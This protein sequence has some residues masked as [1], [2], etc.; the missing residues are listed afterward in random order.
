MGLTYNIQF[1]ADTKSLKVQ[2]ASIKEDLD[3]AFEA[4]TNSELFGQINKAVVSA[5]ALEKAMQK[6]STVNGTSFV[7]LN[8]ELKKAG[9]SASDIVSSFTS[10][11]MQKS[12]SKFIETFTTADRSALV[13]SK[14]IKE[15]GRV[16]TQSFKFSAA[17]GFLR[18]AQSSLQSGLRW[19]IDMN[20]AL[21]N[22]SIVTQKTGDDL[23]RIFE[24]IVSGAKNLNIA[25]KEYAEASLIF[26]Q[27]GLG[28]EEVARRSETTV[29]AAKSA[30]ESTEEMSKNLTTI[31]NTYQM[32]GERLE[33]AA[34]IGARLGAETAVD[35]KY[36]AEA[37]QSSASAAAQLG[38]SYESL[39]AIT[40]TIGSVSGQS[41]S[42]VGN[43]TK[44]I[45]SRFANLKTTGEDEGVTLGRITEQFAE[46]GINV[47]DASGDL[48]ELDDVIMDLGGTW[49]TYSVKQQQAIAQ[50]AGGTRQFGQ[51]LTLMNNF[52]KYKIN[53]QSAMAESGGATLDSQFE[54]WTNSIEAASNLAKESWAQA[55]A[56]MFQ[57]DSIKSF[58][59]LVAA[60]GNVFGDL[61]G[62]VGGLPGILTAIGVIMSSKIA[63]GAQNLLI[64][65][66][67]YL[68][69]LTLT[70][71]KTNAIAMAERA[72]TD[73]TAQRAAAE[74]LGANGKTMASADT[75]AD[76]RYLE[77]KLSV[78]KEIVGTMIDLN[79][80]EQN[81]NAA[82]KQQAAT[83]KELISRAQVK[84][85]AALDELSAAQDELS[86]LQRQLEVQKDLTEEQ[87]LQKIGA[88]ENKIVA[89]E[90]NVDNRAMAVTAFNEE[91]TDIA[92]Q[93][94]AASINYGTALISLASS[95]MSAGFA[96][97]SMTHI[98]DDGKI[99]IGE[100]AGVVMNTSILIGGLT[101]VVKALNISL[102][103]QGILFG[104]KLSAEAVGAQA[105]ANE[106]KLAAE[107]A[108]REAQ[109][110]ENKV[111]EAKIKA[112]LLQ[113]EA[114]DLDVDRKNKSKPKNSGVNQDADKAAKDA[115]TDLRVKQNE[116]NTANQKVTATTKASAAATKTAGTAAAGATL[117]FTALAAIL[118]AV[119]AAAFIF[120]KAW[121]HF[122]NI[123]PKKQLAD[124]SDAANKLKEELAKATEE[125][126][127]LAE[128]FK[129]LRDGEDYINSLT[130]G[131]KEWKDAIKNTNDQVIDLLN[132]YKELAPYIE[133][134]GGGDSRQMKLSQEGEKMALDQANT[135]KEDFSTASTLANQNYRSA[136]A[137]F[138]IKSAF[139]NLQPSL[140]EIIGA[141]STDIGSRGSTNMTMELAKDVTAANQ[142]LNSVIDNWT[143]IV[144]EDV[145]TFQAAIEAQAGVSKREAATFVNE[146]KEIHGSIQE[147]KNSIDTNT[148]VAQIE[149]D[150]RA[151]QLLKDKYIVDNGKA[152]VD[153]A[154]GRILT[155]LLAKNFKEAEAEASSRTT[156]TNQGTTE[157]KAIWSE[158]VKEAQL[159][160]KGAQLESNAFRGDGSV[161]YSSIDEDGN[162]T[163]KVATS[164]DIAN[165]VAASRANAEFNASTEILISTI[166]KLADSYSAADRALAA[167]IG[168]Q[169]LLNVSK[170]GFDELTLDEERNPKEVNAKEYLGKEFGGVD[171][172]LS[173]EEAVALGFA[174]ADAMIAAF[175]EGIAA[176]QIEW[177]ALTLHSDLKGFE[178][179]GLNAAKKFDET[180]QN[181]STGP[182]EDGG[183][184]MVDGF[185]KIT[186][187]MNAEDIEKTL[188]VLTNV[189]WSQWHGADSV[190]NSLEALKVT[191][192]MTDAEWQQFV[193]TMRE[194]N[195]AS[196]I[197]ALQ[198]LTA[199][200]SELYAITSKIEFGSIISDEE[201]QK[202]V[203]TNSAVKDL[204]LTMMDGSHKMISGVD[205]NS[206]FPVDEAISK[207]ENASNMYNDFQ[208]LNWGS[209]E[210]EDRKEADW[211]AYAAGEK[212]SSMA[213]TFEELQT[214][215]VFKDIVAE[216][217]YT[218]ED[219]DRINQDIIDGN[220][221]SARKIMG[222][223]DDFM[224]NTSLEDVS[225]Q[226]F[227][228]Q[229]ST[230]TSIGELTRMYADGTVNAEAYGKS[231]S[232]L[233]DNQTDLRDAFQGGLIDATTYS[234]AFLRLDEATKMEGLDAAE[235]DD[236]GDWLQEIALESDN[237]SDSLATN[238]ELA[239]DVAQATMR[240]NKGVKK[241]ADGYETW[242]SVLTK[243]TKESDEYRK[244][245]TGM[246]DGLADVLNISEDFI[247]NDFVSENLEL[248]EDA[249]KGSEIAI[250]KLQMA[251]AKDIL[252]KVAIDNGL[253]DLSPQLTT[254][255][256]D[257][258]ALIPKDIQVGT[259]LT[260]EDD[261]FIKATEIANAA[262][263]TA[264][265]ANAFFGS[266]GFQ[267]NFETIS[268]PVQKTGYSTITTTKPIGS[269][270][271]ETVDGEGKP[272]GS[273]T[274]PSTETFTKPGTRY[275]YTD[276]VDA[277][278]MTTSKGN[279]KAA[280]KPTIKSF[281][282]TG[283]PKMNDL[284]TSN[285]GGE[286][287]GG[288]GGTPKP[289]KGKRTDK[290]KRYQDIEDSLAGI[291]RRTDK[292]DAAMEN[293][294][295]ANKL[296]L[297]AANNQLLQ[298][299]GI[300]LQKL[301]KEAKNYLTGTGGRPTEFG[302][303]F[304][305][306][307]DQKVLTQMSSELKIPAPEFD[308]DGFVKNTQEMQMA[309]SD[310][311]YKWADAR[312]S[313]DAEAGDWDFGT[314]DAAEAEAKAY[315]LMQKQGE[316]HLKQVEKNNE[317]ATKIVET[318]AERQ[319]NI[320]SWLSEKIK[321][322]DYKL[323]LKINV[324][325]MELR[326]LD[327][328]LDRL[329]DKAGKLKFDA[330]NKSAKV[331]LSSAQALMENYGRLNE[332]MSNINSDAP[333]AQDYFKTT[334]G[335]DAWAKFQEN[336]GALTQE[337]L[338][339]LSE[340]AE[341]MQ[342]LIEDLYSYSEQ[343][344]G[345]FRETLDAY[346]ADFDRLISRF[347]NA[348]SELDA[349][350]KLWDIAGNS[351]KNTEVSI[352]LMNTSISTQASK[353]KSMQQQYQ[354]LVS[355][356][357]NAQKVY[358]AA[359]NAHG[360]DDKITQDA[361]NSWQDLQ[362]EA[363]A[364]KVSI[365][366]G[367]ADIAEKY[368]ELAAKMAETIRTQFES[369]ISGIAADIEG[370]QSMFE[371]K[372]GLDKFYMNGED[373]GLGVGN[374]LD[375]LREDPSKV[376]DAAKWEEYLNSKVEKRIVQT[377]HLGEMR[378]EEVWTTKDGV[379]LTEKEL[380]IMQEEFELAKDQAAFEEQQA[381]KNTMRL[382]R[383]ASGNWSY[384][385]SADTSD[386]E[387]KAQGIEDRIANIRKM[388]REATDEYLDA[389]IKGMAEWS[390][391]E[392]N[393]D[394][395]RYAQDEKYRQQVD[396]QRE[397][398]KQMMDNLSTEVGE[399]LGAIDMD[400]SETTAGTIL[401]LDTM[402]QA[403][404]YFKQNVQQ[405][406]EDYRNNW[407]Q[408][409]EAMK[410]ELKT[411]GFDMNDLKKLIETETN[412]IIG[413]NKENSD[414]VIDLRKTAETE[415]GYL[416]TDIETW[417]TTWQ[418]Q[419][420]DVIDKLREM[421]DTIAEAEGGG[422]SHGYNFNTDYQ[423]E[424]NDATDAEDKKAALTNRYYKAR[425]ARDLVKR[426]KAGEKIK[427]G[428]PDIADGASKE[429]VY[430][431]A[432][433]WTKNIG[434]NMSLEQY[435]A[436][437]LK[438]FLDGGLSTGKQLAW[439]SEDNK[440]ELVLNSHDTEN[441]LEAISI[442]RDGIASYLGNI[443][444]Q[445]A[446][447]ISE[448]RKPT[449][450]AETTQTPVIIQADFPNVSAR[451]EIEAAFENLV[452]RAT[453][454]QI[455][456][457]N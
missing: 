386:A 192:G 126:D 432:E 430:A 331:S 15:I 71:Q 168:T 92:F 43:A 315:E 16:L 74:K 60:T 382:A 35:F 416:T 368:E 51:F 251:A 395:K 412:A 266:M 202:L 33:N 281:E 82:Q 146:F 189:D 261:F 279:D 183:Q 36:I 147:W 353:V 97:E 123:S 405:L 417:S 107:E 410:K 2:L 207:L 149:N 39:A 55:F 164:E 32:Q 318:Q 52:D 108:K 199:S 220:L 345:Q 141:V 294:F 153:Q 136:Q 275:S 327:F 8:A 420:Q 455:K 284:S 214:N 86:L 411:M 95:A 271:F 393:V 246:K 282:Y 169:D 84:F 143:G 113:K 244:A 3:K 391:F 328:T 367:V 265:Q 93:A 263:M 383:D 133:A 439:L 278:A 191:T 124:A 341:D 38:V 428:D 4:T 441:F 184:A 44:T 398:Y 340:K 288:G 216:Y 272:T 76:L 228:M 390:E 160:S 5:Q 91:G 270:T 364:A 103:A 142:A 104:A 88:A 221:E 224:S 308:E 210:G 215:S 172:A 298:E 174:S 78:S 212:D 250:Q 242:N 324:N 274:Y 118:V 105:K 163:S 175:Q 452:N 280:P 14:H 181:A 454:Y 20:E 301:E 264:D 209:G 438:G 134:Y 180:Y 358:E 361:Y 321:T 24:T 286:P 335:D 448:I 287:K 231:F 13:L 325:D 186:K 34:S 130:A 314:G 254:M 87:R 403:N 89:A 373:A 96:I 262:Q 427:W 19:S 330:L 100:I 295:G 167:F 112:A 240:M 182:T 99:S 218:Q 77:K 436:Q 305:V 106:A 66:K 70:Q 258:Q 291:T 48:K 426:D 309:I 323:E 407:R 285:T 159:E 300:E 145:K 45:F 313:W 233:V 223:L 195:N 225:Q 166:N 437:E 434:D 371:Q 151:A 257:L 423:K 40:A 229:A 232:G 119:A 201:Y 94:T 176:A 111:N 267:T 329:G 23:D 238:G 380:A 392:A 150:N 29:K 446:N 319:A 226:V 165:V 85:N 348:S 109:E 154:G 158:Y 46:M 219:I 249:A 79:V 350:T 456:P 162:R 406:S 194:A 339:T 137:D 418:T 422:S 161:H 204:F 102:S 377:E 311:E 10:L 332:I 277:I 190:M 222:S 297:L 241:L 245:M 185:N 357:A 400:F 306:G 140:L 431:V 63:T 290:T 421:I 115:M 304:L 408:N 98:M 320:H 256:D 65:S 433:D 396:Q 338:D 31:W 75:I 11:E 259:K 336:G 425:E 193:A 234:E 401:N 260:G 359:L 346:I 388:H 387:D 356:T 27:Q 49:D 235:V 83:Q 296:R 443:G 116:L 447:T 365:L 217:G 26:Y 363:E 81:G 57:Q 247:S 276:H 25:A 449:T 68:S 409:Q 415:L 352:K 30:G 292:V 90:E 230:A 342:S 64:T 28:D 178:T 50:I 173:D 419:I 444:V 197:A 125:A 203:S 372:K 344:F 157:A 442:M 122:N 171:S 67:E 303:K 213:G 148:S 349:W 47:I 135:K 440:D 404:E 196:P 114:K 394:Q 322:A 379:E 255:V 384:T 127:K 253:E 366:E 399:H 121:E 450:E 248:I 326:Q 445:Q 6:A 236:Y 62:T 56:E 269:E 316:D 152:T 293:A 101:Q 317:T 177:D 129:K 413:K 198:E 378:E 54:T 205:I 110:A 117:S 360:A 453:Q 58:Y 457:R 120:Y 187:N 375:E 12:A 374:M 252:L 155:D 397:W 80:L 59:N 307:N 9:V 351:V 354:F 208:K 376:K 73:I 424:A 200:M 18:F 237:V 53:L 7:A 211:G 451:E 1:N 227:D 239:D 385:Y 402:E 381:A 435:L 188:K 370:L 302:N 179:L 170:A 144:D 206:M 343:I 128:S 21:T 41:A 289:A 22:I 139:E 42:I 37:M 312:A 310:A 429:S 61:I 362:D 156:L 299:Q 268:K 334:F 283:A 333:G 138:D 72:L 131:T 389:V 17:Q 369:S 347:D 273:V 69:N 132:N 414:S 243:S 355:Q 337:M